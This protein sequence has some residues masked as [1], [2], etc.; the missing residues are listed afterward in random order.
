MRVVE[1]ASERAEMKSIW[2]GMAGA[3]AL[4]SVHCGGTSPIQAAPRAAIAPC[5]CPRAV[6]HSPDCGL[7]LDRVAKRVMPTSATLPNDATACLAAVDAATS[8]AFA[9]LAQANEC[10]DQ[11]KNIALGAALSDQEHQLT[12]TGRIASEAALHLNGDATDRLRCET[13]AQGAARLVRNLDQ[14]AA[15]DCDCGGRARGSDEETAVIRT[16]PS[17]VLRVVS[18]SD[19]TDSARFAP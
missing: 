18:V 15:V 10:I 6:G 5:D 13:L 4:F 12:A 3:L 19:D 17:G 14:L 16:A 1:S 8:A 11:A 9:D 2:V 7:F